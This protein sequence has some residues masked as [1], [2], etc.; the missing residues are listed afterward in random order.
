MSEP[1]A[2]S[3]IVKDIAASGWK[4][5]SGPQPA[6]R[7]TL[8]YAAKWLAAFDFE[9]AEATLKDTGPVTLTFEVNGKRAGTLRC[10]Q[11]GAYRF[12]APVPAGLEEDV[13]LVVIIDKPWVSPG[14]GARLGVLVSAA[15]FLEE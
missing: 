10:E 15:G 14:D 8:P 3:L 12:R 2:N 13:T 4:R 7:C 9:V 6:V 5:W 11:A 1:R